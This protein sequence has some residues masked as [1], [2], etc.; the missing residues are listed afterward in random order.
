MCIYSCTCDMAAS[1]F[2]CCIIIDMYIVSFASSLCP[3]VVFLLLVSYVY[4]F[5]YRNEPFFVT[6]VSE[7]F[8]F[9]F[10]QWLSYCVDLWYCFAWFFFHNFS[11]KACANETAVRIK[12]SF[13]NIHIGH[14]IDL[15][16]LFLVFLL[17]SRIRSVIGVDYRMNMISLVESWSFEKGAIYQHTLIHIRARHQSNIHTQTHTHIPSCTRI[18]RASQARKKEKAHK[19]VKEK[20]KPIWCSFSTVSS[21]FYSLIIFFCF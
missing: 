14:Q 6:L 10:L 19:V 9:L 2:F 16:E 1:I 13:H 18:S 8:V 21:V 17:P 15:K 20:R 5:F 4:R 12:F 11:T 3:G 7:P